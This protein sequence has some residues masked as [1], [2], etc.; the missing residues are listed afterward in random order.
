MRDQIVSIMMNEEGVEDSQNMITVIYRSESIVPGAVQMTE[1]HVKA[2]DET[3]SWDKINENTPN[4]LA[5]KNVISLVH[6]ASSA[7][8]NWAFLFYTEGH[9]ATATTNTFDH[10]EDQEKG[11]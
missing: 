6:T 4:E 5:N 2:F 8:S 3:H 1:V 7:I 10:S 11:E 9:A